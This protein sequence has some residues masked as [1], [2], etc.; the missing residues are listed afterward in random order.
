[1]CLPVR[2]RTGSRR[3]VLERDQGWGAI[4]H[5]YN[6]PMLWYYDTVVL[7]YSGPVAHRQFE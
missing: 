7:R 6:A 2:S 4:A 3:Q 1:M 5:Y